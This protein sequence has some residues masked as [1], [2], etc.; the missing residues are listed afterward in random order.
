MKMCMQ[1]NV[2]HRTSLG[3]DAVNVM[4]RTEP[5]VERLS[6]STRCIHAIQRH[7][8]YQTGLR[9]PPPLFNIFFSTM[10]LVAFKDCDIRVL[11]QFRTDRSI[12]N[13]RRL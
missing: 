12:V 6:T 10:L 9:P 13:L 11:I 8:W 3:V 7:S 4:P 1:F 2:M 5:N